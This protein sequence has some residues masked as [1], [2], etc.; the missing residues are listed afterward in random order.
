MPH[1]TV[2]ISPLASDNIPGQKRPRGLHTPAEQYALLSALRLIVSLVRLR[3]ADNAYHSTTSSRF[4]GLAKR[5]TGQSYPLC[6][7]DINNNLN[8]LSGRNQFCP[9]V[10]GLRPERKNNPQGLLCRLHKPF[11]NL[12][13][14]VS[15]Y[16]CNDI[17]RQ[18]HLRPGLQA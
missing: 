14:Y 10:K 8:Y 7:R 18:A 3:P 6:R 16:T 4:A 1:R 15:R 9:P 13:A 5:F 17:H 12:A 11:V 2:L